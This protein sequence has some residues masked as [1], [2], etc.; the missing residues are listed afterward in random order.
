MKFKLFGHNKK[1]GGYKFRFNPNR[2]SYSPGHKNNCAINA[3]R[4]IDIISDKSYEDLSIYA[5]KRK[6]NSD[7]IGIT[8]CEFIHILRQTY[9]DSNFVIRVV[10]FKKSE[11]I[12]LIPG[13]LRKYSELIKLQDGQ[14]FIM[15]IDKDTVVNHMVVFAKL[16]HELYIIDKQLPSTTC[17]ESLI[18]LDTYFETYIANSEILEGLTLSFIEDRNDEDFNIRMNKKLYDMI[19][20]TYFDSCEPDREVL[21]LYKNEPG[22]QTPPYIPQDIDEDEQPQKRRNIQ[23]E[24]G[25]TIKKRK[26]TKKRKTIKKKENKTTA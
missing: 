7:T 2:C 15:S 24:G 23:H 13:F 21:G 25:K 14:C 11:H 5:T 17:Q 8:L 19:D 20:R 22:N 1:T 10:P 18:L 3:L 9:T 12:G 6:Q 26:T 4:C 16:D